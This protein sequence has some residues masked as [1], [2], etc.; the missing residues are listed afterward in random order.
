MIEL[1]SGIPIGKWA[2]E[3]NNSSSLNINY[4]IQTDRIRYFTGINIKSFETDNIEYSV[5]LLA[6]PAGIS[7]QILKRDKYDMALG[8]AAG[9]SFLSRRLK[10]ST[11]NGFNEFIGSSLNITYRGFERISPGIILGYERQKIFEGSN[12]IYI[13]VNIDIDYKQLFP[14]L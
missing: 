9:I 3:I 13:G 7:Y 4:F 12:Y 6:I 14:G 5:A 11:E 2:D 1:G 10:S 8:I